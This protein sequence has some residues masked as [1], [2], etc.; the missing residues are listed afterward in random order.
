MVLGREIDDLWWE[1]RLVDIRYSRLD[2]FTPTSLGVILEHLRKVFL[3]LQSN[4]LTHDPNTVHRVDQSLR[5]GLQ[6]IADQDFHMNQLKEHITTYSRE[7]FR[8]QTLKLC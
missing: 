1:Q 3:K 6:N 2:L 4:A 7:Q 5:F 8:N